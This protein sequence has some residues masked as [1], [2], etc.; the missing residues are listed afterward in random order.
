MPNPICQEIV[1]ENLHGSAVCAARRDF[2]GIQR[3]GLALAVQVLSV[4]AIAV[5]QHGDP[6]AVG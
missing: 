6:V 4:S 3:V 1:S 2:R 5:R